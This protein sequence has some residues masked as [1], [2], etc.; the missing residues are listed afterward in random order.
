MCI[1]FGDVSSRGSGQ[2]GCEV[3]KSSTE[4]NDASET[5]A[6]AAVISERF[7]V[8]IERRIECSVRCIDEED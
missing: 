1:L 4:S 8:E 5:R 7:M 3:W 6:R 2:R